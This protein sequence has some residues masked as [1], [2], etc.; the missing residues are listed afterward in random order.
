MRDYLKWV[1]AE[2]HQ[3]RQRVRELEAGD[4]EPIAIVAM[5][6][7][8][9][10]GVRTP[11][12]LW[13]LVVAGTDAITPFPQ[14]RGWTVP[15]GL[16]TSGE[17]GFLTDVA[18][19]DAA[20][21]GISPREAVAMDP[22]Q[23]LL[24]EVAWETLERAGIDP[25]SLRGT[26]TGVFTGTASQDYVG[27][28]RQAP[29]GSEGHTLTGN[30][31]SIVSGRIAYSLGLEG[32]AVSV[33]TACSTSLVA[34]H[35]AAAALRKEECG[36]ALAGGASV[37]S[38]PTA[39]LGFDD[40]GGLAADGRCK[41]FSAAAD[42][43]SW[44]EGAAFV[45]LERLADA[46]RNGHPVLAV[47]R[48]SAVNSDGAS[49]GLT[50]PNGP[51]QQRVI[52]R[53]L[54]DARL[55]PS[56]VDAVEAHGTGTVL[57]DPIEAQALLATYGQDRERPLLLGSVKS[58]I[59]HTQAAAGMAG[60]IKMVQAMHHGM[61]PRTLHLDTPTPHVDWS[62]GAVTLLGEE[63]TWPVTGR[64]RRVGVSSFGM[65]G[66]NA[67]VILEQAPDEELPGGTGGIPPVSPWVLSGR[68]AA[69]LRAQEERLL[70][71]VADTDARPVDIGA[72]LTTRT[73][74][75]HRA[76]VFDREQLTGLGSGAVRGSASA[77]LTAVLFTG[78]GSQ[79]PG[80][81]REL[82]EA[83]PVFAEAFDAVCAELDRHLDRPIRNTVFHDDGDAGVLD[84]TVYAQAGLFALQVALFR[85]IESWGVV[86]DSLL[87]H[88]IGELAAAHVAGVWDL[89]D[90]ARVVAARGRLMQALPEGGAMVAV[91]ATEDEVIPLVGAGVSLAAVN[92]PAAVVLSGERSAVA[93]VVDR[94][95]DRRVRWLRVS[96]A[97]HSELMD[98]MLA[99]YRAVLASVVFREPVVP[100]VSTVTGAL[101]GTGWC[102][103][104]YWVR[105]V[106]ETVRFGAAVER[107][108]ELGVSR[109][110]ELGPDGVLSAMGQDCAPEGVFVP[111][112]RRDRPEPETVVGALASLWVTGMPVDWAAYYGGCGAR[113]V[114]L[115]T[116]AFQHRRF[117][118]TTSDSASTPDSDP[119][120]ARFWDAVEREDRSALA[121]L[122][123][124][125]DTTPIEAALP[126]LS[127]WRRRRRVDDTI[128]SWRYREVWRPIAVDTDPVLTGTWWIVTGPEQSG[129][130]TAEALAG[131]LTRRGAT[132]VPLVVTGTDSALLAAQL[133]DAPRPDGILS[134][135]AL[136]ADDA[137]PVPAGLAATD[138]LVKAVGRTAPVWCLTRAAVSVGRSD[139]APVPAQAMT[140]GYGRVA[141][142]ELARTWGGLI[143][144]PRTCDERA[145]T[146][147]CGVLGGAEDQ[148]AVRTSGVFAR[149]LGRAARLDGPGE[150]WAP[151]G[152]VLITGATGAIGGHL[153]RWLA[154]EGADHLVLTSRRGADA[155]GAA[156]L[157]EELAA[158][159]AR[160]TIATC[161]V[162]DRAALTDLLS[163][164]RG[165]GE[166]ITAVLH[167]AGVRQLTTIDDT[168]P[169]EFARI[170]TGK[171]LGAANLD[172]AFADDDLDAFI[173][174]SSISAV[175]GSGGQGAYAAGGAYLDAL[176][177]RR[178]SAGLP[179]TSVAWGVWDGG[180]MSDGE[181]G[182]ALGRR[183]LS[184]MSPDLAVQALRQ[185]VAHRE[186]TVTV[187][188]VDWERFAP[189][190]TVARPSPLIGDLPEV[191]HVLDVGEIDTSG[192][193][194]LR[195]E[196]EGLP[197][198]ERAVAVLDLVRAEAGRAL[199][200]T[201]ADELPA[202]RAFRDLGLDSITA[203]DLRDRV[204]AATGL[205]LP[206]T[207]VFDHPTPAAVA[208]HLLA[209]TFG[210]DTDGAAEV[211]AG[212]VGG[213]DDPVVIVGMS[214]RFPGGVRSPEQL[215]EML[216]SGGDAIGEFPTDRG[217]DVDGLF[218]PDPDV[219]GTSYSTRGGFLDD[220]TRFDAAFFGISPREAVAMDPQQRL[221]LELSWEAL[222]RAGI[223]PGSLRGSRTG[224]FVGASPQGYGN[225]VADLPDE[226]AGY[227]MTGTATAVLS[228][229]VAYTLG[230][231]G[232][233]LTVDT[234]C[235]SSLAALHLAAQALR[236]GE[237]E[238]AL[239]GGVA[240]MATPG[241]F[242][243][244]S[245]QRGLAA[246]GR[247]KAFADSADGT[248]WS[249]GVGVLVVER[250]STARAHHHEVLA[251]V[252]G[253]AINSDGASNGLSAPNGPS[254]SRVIRQALAAAQLEASQVD[255]VEGHGTGTTLGDPIEAQALLATYG[256]DRPADRPLRLGSVK[257]NL[258]HTQAAA[259]VAGV[260]KMV[261]AMRHGVLPRTLHVDQP[262]T[263]VD[264]SSGAVSLLTDQVD[265]PDTDE[266]RRA[267]VSSFGVSGTNVHTVLE[268][269]PASHRAP[270]G[271]VR[272]PAL[273]PWL[274]SGRTAN[275]LRAQAGRLAAHVS[276]G[277]GLD[278]AY[279]L[280]TT[281]THLEHR[282]VVLSE[283]HGGQVAALAA[284]ADGAQ[285]ADVVLGTPTTGGT[286]F[287]FAGQ[288]AQRPAMGRELY[289]TYPVF[290]DAFDEVCAH[291]DRHLD[292]PLADI[293]LTGE[294]L[295]R[296]RHTQPALF[297]V[298]VALFRLL[299]S[300]GVRPDVLLGHSVGELAAVHV[301]GV[302]S[303]S[304]AA[305]LVATRA[306]LMDA[307]PEGGA[308]VSVR[309]TEAEV[310]PLL[311]EHVSLAAV[312]GPTTVVVSGDEEAVAAVADH[313]ATQ[314]RRTRRLPVSHAFHSPR[315][316]PMLDEY[317]A[318]AAGLPFAAPTIPIIS[319]V[320]GAP[321]TTRELVDPDYWARQVS[322]P[323]R[324]LDA[325]LAT[326]ERGV[327][328]LVELGPDG[329]LTGL[330]SHCLPDTEDL[331][332]VPTLRPE[333]AE[334][335]TV[336][337]ALANIHAAGG[338]VDWAAYYARSGATHVP[339]PT[340]AFEPERF[341]LRSQA[342]PAGPPG[343]GTI[344]HPLLTGVVDEAHADAVLCTGSL[345]L[346][347][348]PWL[349]D[350]AVLGTVVFPGAGFVELAL[351]AG[352]QARC[353]RLDELTIEAPLVLPAEGTVRL[354]VRA[355]PPDETGARPV[356]IHGR[357]DDD[358]PWT[359]HAAGTLAP[360]SPQRG[361]ALAEW[362]PTGATPVPVD[363]FYDALVELGYGYGPVFQGLTS[364]WTHGGDV[365][366]DVTL[367][368]EDGGG[369]GLHPALLDSA[370]HG[371]GLADP[372]ESTSSRLPF[373]WNGV[374]LHAPGASAL[375]VR[376]SRAVGD[377]VA[378]TLAD[379]AGGPVAEIESLVL[380]PVTGAQ[381]GDASR[382]RQDSL[383]VLDWTAVDAPAEANAVTLLGSTLPDADL[384]RC[385]ELADVASDAGNFAVVTQFASDGDVLTATH[386][387]TSAALDF[388]LAWFADDGF[389]RTP[390]VVLTRGGVASGPDETVTDLAQAALWG[391]LRSAQ[392]EHPGRLTIIDID[393]TPESVA[394]LPHAVASENPQ[395]VLRGGQL[396]APALN[397]KR[398]SGA[399][400]APVDPR[401]TVLVTGGS[402]VLAQLVARRMVARGARHLVLASRQGPAAPGAE[403][404][405]AE[406]A[407]L[408]A[409]TRFVAC[410]VSDRNEV[411][412]LL[413]GIRDEHPLRVVVHTAG[414]LDD[415]VLS[416]LT[417]GRIGT[418][419]A[420]KADAAWHLHELTRSLDLSAFVLFSSTAATFGSPGQ[421]NYAAANAFLDALAHHRAAAGLP[422]LSLG[423]GP[424]AESGMLGNLDAGGIARFARSGLVPLSTEQGAAL[425][426]A[427]DQADGPAVLVARPATSGA[428]VSIDLVPPLLR[429]L[430]PVSARPRTEVPATTASELRLRLSS[431]SEEDRDRITYS[432]VVEAA[433]AVLGHS[434]PEAIERGRGFLDI[435]F[436]SL[437]AVELRNRLNAVTGLRLPATLV[438]DHPTPED[439]AEHVRDE[440]VENTSVSALWLVGELDRLATAFAAVPEGDDD[441]ARVTERL[442]G[443]LSSW[444]E[445]GPAAED[446]SGLADA[447]ADQIFDLLDEELGVAGPRPGPPTTSK[448]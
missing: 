322:D 18:D 306:R 173:L 107:T 187:V 398:G 431:A 403:D 444:T 139:E 117:W 430:L 279:S 224:V 347:T 270:S 225:G 215:W 36:L 378:L 121:D 309:A 85:L 133:G 282:A 97:F 199:G 137:V 157:V 247:C 273:T 108:R 145:L 2:L 214:C 152:T 274:V 212:V 44:G 439:L 130:Q 385:A 210:A 351:Q 400:P 1:S 219:P 283:D 353:P 386:A 124:V 228:G 447:T 141:G 95:G 104:E 423:W 94:L 82:T 100:V 290:A 138:A 209:E 420:P 105:Q 377:A 233:A 114:P 376:I 429:P 325:V 120:D 189:A 401:G 422:A 159:G 35:L 150:P 11:E 15:P 368:T 4:R 340:Y 346:A 119:V 291:L 19:F 40:Q 143:D 384:P 275:A 26:N 71:F 300:W 443:L 424:W 30:A 57:G 245:R 357:E 396:R 328:I 202:D 427:V 21:F 395:L 416:S 421:A 160:T 20:F 87:G 168:G 27:V 445:Q 356:T 406:L 363:G 265:W 367:P 344:G 323:V 343:L 255:V 221:L 69:A 428:Q 375:R 216:T 174:F 203:V 197:A 193:S 266:P 67:H 277:S 254:Q 388:L 313:F 99:E 294:G 250:L 304:D 66:T 232:P 223:P 231:E 113:R 90:A 220:A 148:V 410:D 342:G 180:G 112:L 191:R 63:T 335:R 201:D 307:L 369:F 296:T 315:M 83:F 278:I 91:E 92:G 68:S 86:P 170:V 177:A 432:V 176:A 127:S 207:L 393:D 408:G 65:S 358:Q 397:R 383:F 298:E 56:E 341:W 198:R 418:V 111:V 13:R 389:D 260:I 412:S 5:A 76:V 163:A 125:E 390:L 184:P 446:P 332:L 158:L 302:L 22:Q 286:A 361:R 379:T 28:L 285:P 236:G 289:D 43:T 317:R 33:D 109:F 292:R 32:A 103:P 149:R 169:D 392:L 89:P 380:R 52:L 243:E 318:F 165:A 6:C 235:S 440:L 339:L 17:G 129:D 196:L 110:L 194:R 179:A 135:L 131:A 364:A 153:A 263:R 70:E 25:E 7:R 246:D 284:L 327:T 414:V 81:G 61:L 312:N 308:M 371:I 394:A 242:V 182:A 448:E 281:R 333:R 64:P 24:L 73:S 407:D 324:F 77:G 330:A 338:T 115:P 128:G 106:R 62:A 54:A 230:L 237:C 147:V 438:F 425:F 8:F 155:P 336:V 350:H 47:L 195:T 287:L 84:Q 123:A 345:S 185:V 229:R 58:N 175:W 181:V 305:A 172:A 258:G 78:Q 310:R 226:V 14:D 362:P 334:P 154:R 162:A 288:G 251:V 239:V 402:G 23:R 267:A 101:A 329:T 269:A 271:D 134:F 337:T 116:Y 372:D 164:L 41:P 316:R 248:G 190:F 200:Y 326:R 311:S 259:G 38:T 9:P 72:A 264:W 132:V 348:H 192:T 140:W 433:A 222:E 241:T 370:L 360:A 217:W 293:V 436:D 417:P 405:A 34:L 299:H 45:L 218:G 349:A 419:L 213:T 142:V 355:G 434:S 253:S 411:A 426:D 122:L 238:R 441:R 60:V 98:P 297:A 205:R 359:R 80:M 151:R 49:N 404:L 352:A 240:V 382:S 413:A 374:T 96:H 256:R 50:A 208:R 399:E 88:S 211:P 227:L 31:A 234:A 204:S 320:T 252:R 435:G 272:P 51:A 314:G 381:L 387:V 280:A 75:E 261:L 206:T 262:S 373:A 183:G 39:F 126:A 93:G 136:T 391:L 295:D 161:D 415:G 365:Y 37:M 442:R 12:D 301:A 118:P 42:G 102:D 244:F 167:T 3:T 188:D 268:Q 303:L 59:G 178:R 29:E 146:R 257:S 48:G 16:S 409:E 156:D 166:T 319:T 249:E 331:T 46:R 437:T 276:E 186:T 74:F 53:A 171:V 10:G 79:R 55:A 366:A 354:Q 321:V 144:L